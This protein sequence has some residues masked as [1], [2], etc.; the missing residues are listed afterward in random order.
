ML[1]VLTMPVIWPNLRSQYDESKIVCRSL[2]PNFYYQFSKNSG[3]EVYRLRDY[4][5][6]D[7]NDSMVISKA[8]ELNSILISLNG[9]FADIVMYPPS[10]YKGII[11]V[12]LRNHPEI[13]P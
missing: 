5:P 3:F 12:Q 10:D 1:R 6:K 8:Q 4:I 11:A 2:N 13:I 7:S 9:D